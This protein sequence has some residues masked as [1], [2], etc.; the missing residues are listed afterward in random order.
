MTHELSASRSREDDVEQLPVS[1]ASWS[2]RE[3]AQWCLNVYPS[4]SLPRPNRGNE[5]T[6]C[7]LPICSKLSSEPLS[8][9]ALQRE[10]ITSALACDSF[11]AFLSPQSR[12]APA[13]WSF[14]RLHDYER[15]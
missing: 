8:K 9:R 12:Q 11:G 6:P 3:I 4:V 1:S 15:R 13:R 14:G 7:F 5:Q 2:V 10:T